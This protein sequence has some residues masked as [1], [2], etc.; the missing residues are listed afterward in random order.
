[1]SEKNV[2]GVK[3]LKGA[4]AVAAAAGQKSRIVSTIAQGRVK[5][6][7]KSWLALLEMVGRR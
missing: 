4:D 7:E 5:R 3:E 1:M 6:K 2:G